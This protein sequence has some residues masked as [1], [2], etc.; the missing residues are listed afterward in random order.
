MVLDSDYRES[1]LESR[2]D[3]KR[4]CSVAGQGGYNVVRSRVVTS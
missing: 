3:A 1:V 2:A 4:D